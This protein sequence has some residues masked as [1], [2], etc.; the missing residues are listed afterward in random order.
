MTPEEAKQRAAELIANNQLDLAEVVAE[1]L[2]LQQKEPGK[3]KPVF[4]VDWS[5]L[6]ATQESLR[7]HMAL[8]KATQERERQF[9]ATVAAAMRELRE[10]IR[11][12]IA[13]SEKCCVDID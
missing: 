12:R 2:M 7:E 3:V 1:W 4:S 5:L 9:R 10:K 11:Q 8:A 13:G 6:K